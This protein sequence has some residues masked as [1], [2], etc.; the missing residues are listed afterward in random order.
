MWRVA[1]VGNERQIGVGQFAGQPN[2][3]PGRH[4]AIVVARD[5]EQGRI[6]SLNVDLRLA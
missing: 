3:L 2:A 1:A 6:D 5:D 4:D